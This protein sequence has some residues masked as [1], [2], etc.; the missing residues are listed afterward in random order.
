MTNR[1]LKHSPQE[2]TCCGVIE[3]VKYNA[4]EKRANRQTGQP[5]I[6][7]KFMIIFTIGIMAYTAYVYIAR[8]CVKMIHRQNGA[9]GSRGAGSE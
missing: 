4:R 5:W 9:G 8:F 7:L 1:K 6:V 3:E 2:R